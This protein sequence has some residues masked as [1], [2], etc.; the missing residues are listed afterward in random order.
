MTDTFIAG[1]ATTVVGML[2]VFLI[3]IMLCG[4]LY[5]L[6]FA[7]PDQKKRVAKEIEETKPIEIK[8]IEIKKEI[9]VQENIDNTELIAVIT[10]AI[11]ASLGTTSNKLQIKS[12][13]KVQNWNAVNRREQQ[14][15]IN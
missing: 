11:A 1:L 15:N 5:L 9:I 6:R 14:R 13:V 10:A 12:I 7:N 4:V 3:L 2:T 8:P